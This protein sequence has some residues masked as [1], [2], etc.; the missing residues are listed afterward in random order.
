MHLSASV[1]LSK[2]TFD[3]GDVSIWHDKSPYFPLRNS[4]SVMKASTLYG[5]HQQV[6]NS[7]VVN[8]L[9]YRADITQELHVERTEART[10]PEGDPRVNLIERERV[11]GLIDAAAINR[12]GQTT[13]PLHQQRQIVFRRL[14]TTEI[15]LERGDQI[16]CESLQRDSYVEQEVE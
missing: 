5:L 8:K 10:D 15:T 14:V 4:T 1:M 2:R 11:E 16:A 6:G 9:K 13:D 7:Q 12:A 3:A